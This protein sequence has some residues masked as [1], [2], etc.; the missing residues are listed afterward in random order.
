LTIRPVD[1][2]LVVEVSAAEDRTPGGIYLPENVKQKPTTG[3]VLAAGPRASAKFNLKAGDTV[4]FQKYA[5]VPVGDDTGRTAM[6]RASEIM[7][8]VSTA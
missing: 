4:L 7:G 5:G 8:T 1:D 2:W 3:K 6:M